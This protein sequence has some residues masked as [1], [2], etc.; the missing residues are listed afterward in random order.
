MIL[1]KNKVMVGETF[2][3]HILAKQQVKSWL[4]IIPTHVSKKHIQ[5]CFDEFVFR[6]IDHKVKNHLI[7]YIN[8]TRHSTFVNIEKRV[9][10]NKV[11]ISNCYLKYMYIL[12]L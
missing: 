8:K 5:A 7:N 3:N 4:R 1:L 12:F 11:A 2:L 9:I 6:I 10:N